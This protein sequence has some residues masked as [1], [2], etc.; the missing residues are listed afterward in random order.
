MTIFHFTIFFTEMID[1][2]QRAVT[3]IEVNFICNEKTDNQRAKS[4]EK[5]QLYEVLC[6]AYTKSSLYRASTVFVIEL[7]LQSKKI[8][9]LSAI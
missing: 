3:Y 6:V 1:R 2:A 5:P 4:P 9:S 7:T 8:R